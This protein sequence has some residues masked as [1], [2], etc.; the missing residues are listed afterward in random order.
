ML[1][2]TMAEPSE[3]FLIAEY[4]AL[5]RE[6]EI[7]IRD[8]GPGLSDEQRKHIFEA[9]YT[10]KPGGTGLGLAVS[11][12]LV[13]EMGGDLYYVGSPKGASFVV[14]VPAASDA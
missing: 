12:Q 9:F 6:I 11:R 13:T 8:S 1:R 4:D 7:E 5:R 14:A 2:L 10:T 3:T